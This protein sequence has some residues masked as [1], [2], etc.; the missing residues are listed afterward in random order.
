MWLSNYCETCEGIAIEWP[1]M[2]Q[3]AKR[4]LCPGFIGQHRYVTSSG[5]CDP[6]SIVDIIVDAGL[7]PDVRGGHDDQTPLHLAA[8]NGYSALVSKLLD[9]GADISIRSGNIHNNSPAGWAIVAGSA[10]VFELLMDR[11]AEVLD[12]FVDDAV[13]AAAGRFAQ[14][15]CVPQSNYERILRRLR[16]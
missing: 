15:K 8:W 13:A 7:S 11:G 3:N 14:Y 6:Q 2:R 4:R 12:W 9:R 16:P 5:C 10:D 1:T